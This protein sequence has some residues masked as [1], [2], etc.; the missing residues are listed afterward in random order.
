MKY[1]PLFLLLVLFCA[2]FETKAQG[3]S[4][5]GICTAGSNHVHSAPLKGDSLVEAYAKDPISF[6]L[7]YSPSF[8]GG[9]VSTQ[10]FSNQLEVS[11]TIGNSWEFSASLPY[12]FISGKLGNHHGLGDVLLTANYSHNI[13]DSWRVGG[14][15]GAKIR[16][17]DASQI[18]NGRP[19]PMAY[20]TSL[21]TN[22]LLLGG[23]VSY[24]QRLSLVVGYQQP[25]TESNQ[26][27]FNAASWLP[28]TTARSFDNT[29]AFSRKPDLIANL[30]Y[31]F[32]F[33][34]WGLSASALSIFH[35]G[36]DI[37][38]QSLGQRVSIV[39][40]K[41]VTLNLTFGTYYSI[42]PKWQVGLSAGM[43]LLVREARPDGLTRAFVV[44]PYVKYSF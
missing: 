6:H 3:C 16:T 41:G 11:A 12:T 23:N 13:G 35:L 22:D 14:L 36:D 1:L 5:A 39:D 37:A 43:P 18:S 29:L 32:K 2:N 10:Y 44:N 17:G 42:S 31:R 8:G 40:S 4:D 24:K 7:K 25:L 15:L 28:D 21:G 34:Q 38:T 27:A 20:Q 26:N 9:E 30:S 19:L 33:K